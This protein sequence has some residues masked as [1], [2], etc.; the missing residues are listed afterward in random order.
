[1]RRL[2]NRSAKHASGKFFCPDA[3]RSSSH[4]KI[5]VVDHPRTWFASRSQQQRPT[6]GFAR[7]RS[8]E[9]LSNVLKNFIGQSVILHGA[10]RYYA[11][12][13]RHCLK[14]GFFPAS[15]LSG[16]NVLKSL[17]ER[18]FEFRGRSS[19]F[20]GQRGRGALLAWIIPVPPA[21]VAVRIRF[22]TL[23]AIAALHAA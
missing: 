4:A 9:L 21:Q 18:G 3:G 16:E 8:A 10:S 7:A 2:E 13:H 1:M 15:T 14:Y 22:L 12:D 23:L 17:L 6:F 20:L 5:R 11:A 19:R